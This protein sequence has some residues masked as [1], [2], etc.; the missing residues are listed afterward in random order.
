VLLTVAVQGIGQA[1]AE[2]FCTQN[3]VFL[4]GDACHT[5]SSGSAQGLNTGVHEYA[6]SVFPC[7]CFHN[8]LH[9][10]RESILEASRE[11]CDAYRNLFDGRA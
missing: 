7:P 1:I 5:H 9:Q 11:Q 6:E 2:T 4:A 10:R 8:F 3:R